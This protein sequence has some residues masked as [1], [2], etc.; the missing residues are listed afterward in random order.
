MSI[1]SELLELL[2][3]NRDT[4]LSGEMLAWHLNCTRAA[5]WKA[6]KA[7]R[8]DGY[9]IEA[10]TNRGYLLREESNILSEEGIRLYLRDKSLPVTVW[11]QTTSTN[12]VMKEKAM[13]E[14]LPQGTVMA[15]RRQSA[16]RGRRGRSFY[17]P[18]ASGLYLSVLLKPAGT[19][20]DSLFLTAAAAVAVCRAVESVCGLSLSIKWV[21]DLYLSGK[22]V[23]G[24]LTEAVTDFETGVVDFAVV[25]IGLNLYEPEE[26]FPEPLRRTAGSLWGREENLPVS[27]SRLAAEI[28]NQLLLLASQERIPQEYAARNLVQGRKVRLL[29]RT[30]TCLVQ[31]LK[32]L[33]DGSLLVEHEDGG[34]EILRYG[35]VSLELCDGE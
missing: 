27:R 2:R 13:Q 17:S 11:D 20:Q 26:G 16:G 30:E 1:K 28:V 21:N 32:I 29:R 14:P 31:A 9:V 18:S 25:G 5:V 4:C 10:A 3:D 23:C 7:L 22:K 34:R 15:A 6:V 12:Q 33:A 19:V 24:I 8:E 35:E